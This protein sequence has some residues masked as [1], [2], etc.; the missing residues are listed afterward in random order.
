MVRCGWHVVSKLVPLD[1]FRGDS[2][3]K[4]DVKGKADGEKA[5]SECFLRTIVSIA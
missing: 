1:I 3:N 2:S 4:T 5:D